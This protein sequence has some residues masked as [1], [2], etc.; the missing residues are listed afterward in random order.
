MSYPLK[1]QRK[2]KFALNSKRYATIKLKTQI[3]FEFKIKKQKFQK[4]KNL[5]KTKTRNFKFFQNF[6]Q[7][8]NF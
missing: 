5:K 6:F 8:K 1:K 2:S 3:P 7:K 4:M